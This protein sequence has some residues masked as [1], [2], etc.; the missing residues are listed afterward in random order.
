MISD[1]SN[2]NNSILIKSPRYTG[3]DFMFL[4]RFVRCRRLTQILVHSITFE[5]RFRFL[6]FLARLL[7]LTYRLPDSMLVDYRRDLDLEFSRSNMEFAISQPKMVRLPRN[8]KQIYWLKSMPQM[9]P[10]GLTLAMTLTLYIQSQI[11]NL[12][13]L[14][15]KWP[16]YY[17]AESKHIDWTQGLKCD[18]QIWPW[19]WP[20]PVNFQGQMWPWPLTTHMA[21]TVDN[22][23]LR[24]G[25][26]IDVEQRWWK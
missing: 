23:Y 18:H 8:E 5:R 11:W 6:F 4:H 25:G 22:C 17:E 10:S 9:W 3:G 1:Y 26:P 12:L 7:A 15:Q 13:Y 19:P 14:S 20:W 16:D 24:M 2:Y 21:L